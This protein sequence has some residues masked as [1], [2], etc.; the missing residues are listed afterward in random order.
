[1]EQT[2]TETTNNV[3]FSKGNIIIL[4]L[5]LT[6][7]FLVYKNYNTAVNKKTII[8][9]IYLY[10]LIAILFV[11]YVG[12]FL[13][14]NLKFETDNYM[15]FAIL[16]FII[17]FGATFLMT[18][19]NFYISHI[20]FLLLLLALSLIIGLTVDNNNNNNIKYIAKLSSFII[21]ALTTI[22]F[23]LSETH[24]IRL[25]K[26]LPTLTYI[27]LGFII[28]QLINI[29]FFN[30]NAT[31]KKVLNI[32]IFILFVLLILSNTSKLLLNSKNSNCKD[33]SCVNYPLLSTFLIVDY[34]GL[35]NMLINYKE[36]KE[37]LQK[38][39]NKFYTT[40]RNLKNK[41]IH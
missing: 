2:L 26:F 9:N 16:Y 18:R 28:L 12:Q 22:I 30:S 31:T 24:L 3:I 10:I 32:S 27:L 4:V 40:I 7:I 8:I 34:I 41:Y 14:N 36:N 13:A 38:E 33:H 21:I 35:F 15:K 20:G 17:A 25:N 23:I 39:I 19:N 29:F 5:L 1:M 6:S 37:N 11:V